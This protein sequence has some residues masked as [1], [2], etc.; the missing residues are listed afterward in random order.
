MPRGFPARRGLPL[1]QQ[2]SGGP[3]ARVR[4]VLRVLRPRGRV[5]LAA[6][7]ASARPSGR[8]VKAA[9]PTSKV[10]DLL[11]GRVPRAPRDLARPG[12]VHR[13]RAAPGP[14]PAAR[15]L[16]RGQAITR[17]ARPRPAWGQH[18][19]PGRRRLVRRPLPARPP[20]PVARVQLDAV[21]AV[22]VVLAARV[23]AVLLVPAARVLAV[24]GR[25]R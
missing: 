13:V 20:V 16:A 9:G 12:L 8:A 2:T 1:S 23:L 22:L 18:L 7:R 21:L 6:G 15:A 10:R 24:P 5:R 17:S 25:V 4:L 11:P 14:G 19:R 3:A